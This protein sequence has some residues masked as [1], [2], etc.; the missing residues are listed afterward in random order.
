M[1]ARPRSIA[2]A[3]ERA[4]AARSTLGRELREARVDRDLSLDVVS[5]AVGI[6]RPQ[7]SRIER[8]MAPAVSLDQL[9]RVAAAVG[10]DLACRLHPGGEPIRDAAH[11]ALIGRF[12]S[13][14]H[15]SLRLRTEVPLP[16]D[17]DRRAWDALVVGPGWALP[18]EA[19]TRPRD[20][21]ALQ[22]RIGLKLRDAGLEH[23]LLLLLDSAHGRRLVRLHGDT[24]RAEFPV[25]GARAL[26]LLR[27]GVPTG[28]S[29]IVLL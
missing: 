26:E 28:G 14:L 7:L 20:L 25:P 17:G 19:E 23:V 5:E 27:A 15:R 24:L 6:S 13:E 22:R 4:R 3:A 10:L 16:R 29:A 21:Q 9:A 2:V 12:R 18:V 1:A 11:A 8:G